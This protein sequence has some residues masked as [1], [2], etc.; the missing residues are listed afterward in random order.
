ML[1]R[2]TSAFIPSV[3]FQARRNLSTMVPAYLLIDLYYHNKVDTMVFINY[4]YI[5][6][7]DIKQ[8]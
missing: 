3:Y 7:D 4:Y 6:Y 5:I 2:N 1:Y 8:F